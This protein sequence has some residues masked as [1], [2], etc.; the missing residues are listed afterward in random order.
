LK[1]SE[2]GSKWLEDIRELSC[3]LEGAVGLVQGQVRV[4]GDEGIYRLDQGVERH[5][6]V[7]INRGGDE[8][9]DAPR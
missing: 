7:E 4:F 6:V 8:L 3:R 5:R 1:A 9:R 2:G